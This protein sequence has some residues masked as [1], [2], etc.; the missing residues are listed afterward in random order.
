MGTG[1]S[2][3]ELAK[4]DLRM[5]KV[6]LGIHDEISINGAAYHLQQFVEKWIKYQIN[7]MGESYSR[8]HDI[9]ILIGEAKS[10]NVFIPEFMENDAGRFDAWA[11]KTRYGNKIVT[12]R[13]VLVRVL[14]EC[15]K[16]VNL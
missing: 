5:A 13:E 4:S 9:D 14:T 15:E 3:L 10:A 2:L 16:L 8:V 1:Y 7:L 6:I 12:T 11:V